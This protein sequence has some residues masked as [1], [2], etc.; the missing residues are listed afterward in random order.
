MGLAPLIFR[1]LLCVGIV[2]PGPW[3]S[4]FAAQAPDASGVIQ[5]GGDEDPDEDKDKEDKDKDEDD[6]DDEDDDSDGEGDE[7][8][9]KDGED[10]EDQEEASV[11]VTI[12]YLTSIEWRRGQEV[13]AEVMAFDGKLVKIAGYMATGTPVGSSTFELVPQSC[14]CGR[15]KLHHFVHVS[16]GDGGASFDPGRRQFEGILSIGEEEDE[17]GFVTSL[18]RLSVE[19]FD[20]QDPEDEG[21]GPN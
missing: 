4:V 18:Y 21:R 1:M 17:D 8:E 3:L 13:P 2:L 9:D 5:D 20:P 12:E 19:T 16:I 15:S 11:L 6:E 7:E 10:G 14:E